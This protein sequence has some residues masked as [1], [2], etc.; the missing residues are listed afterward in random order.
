MKPRALFFPFSPS[1]YFSVFQI[2]LNRHMWHLPFRAVNPSVSG[3]TGWHG[4]TLPVAIINGIVGIQFYCLRV[5]V[6]CRS[7]IFFFHVVIAC[8]QIGTGSVS[9][10]WKSAKSDPR[11]SAT[12]TTN[13]RRRSHAVFFNH[14]IEPGS[15][16]SYTTETLPLVSW[17]LNHFDNME[18]RELIFASH[19]I[20]LLGVKAGMPLGHRYVFSPCLLP[21]SHL[22]LAILLPSP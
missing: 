20:Q 15:V 2:F 9:R 6:H 4:T 13:T 12:E 7:V 14:K 11:G 18:S 5:A 1:A 22:E 19:E 10:V 21:H 8:N 3:W 16:L 17:W